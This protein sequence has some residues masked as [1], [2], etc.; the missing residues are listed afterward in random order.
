M[1]RLA[2]PKAEFDSIR[3][4]T[5]RLRWRELPAAIQRNLS[6][7]AL[8]VPEKTCP[9]RTWAPVNER[10]RGWPILT[11]LF[12]PEISTTSRAA[13]ESQFLRAVL[14]VAEKQRDVAFSS[15]FG[16]PFSTK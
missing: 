8:S 4:S 5:Q 7:R 13:P 2:A 1:S 9:A 14:P 3:R 12:I 11:M 15:E 6:R 16:R 10:W